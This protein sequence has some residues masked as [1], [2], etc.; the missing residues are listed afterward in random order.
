MRDAAWK[1]RRSARIGKLLAL[2]LFTNFLIAAALS[3][4]LVS[5]LRYSGFRWLSVRGAQSVETYTLS[6]LGRERRDVRVWT[7]ESLQLVDSEFARKMNVLYGPVP[8]KLDTTWRRD[9]LEGRLVSMW[10]EEAA[11]LPWLSFYKW[12]EEG[13]AL[14]GAVPLPDGQGLRSVYPGQNFRVFPYSPIW[15][16][17]VANTLF[18][19][20][21]WG[22]A[23]FVPGIL[24]RRHRR[25][26]GLC[27]ACGY[28]LSASAGAC[29][30]CGR[31]KTDGDM[32][33]STPQRGVGW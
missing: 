4:G 31:G 28:D 26:R 33:P 13:E 12:Q 9:G 18:W 5:G 8:M 32:R 20:G 19:A 10:I 29:P 3:E 24:R 6:G 21:L 30:E 23:I 22:A 16:G 2:G 14:R 25:K 7:A 1:S 27:V 11:G 15:P 17:L